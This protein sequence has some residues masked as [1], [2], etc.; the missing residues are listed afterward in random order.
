MATLSFWER[1]PPLAAAAAGKLANLDITFKPDPKGNKDTPLV[2]ALTSED[3]FTGNYL[4]LRYIARS[5]P[6]SRLYGHDALSST[7]VSL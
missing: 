4:I 3:S 1:Q 6:E 7:Q 2:L 5:S